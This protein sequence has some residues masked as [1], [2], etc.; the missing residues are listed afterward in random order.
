MSKYTKAAD[1]HSAAILWNALT[2]LCDN[3]NNI[4]IFT[5]SCLYDAVRVSVC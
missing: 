5:R 1:Q 2:A 3:I 4:M